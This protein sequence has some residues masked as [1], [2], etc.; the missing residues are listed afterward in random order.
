MDS[1]SLVTTTLSL[2]MII[3]ILLSAGF[4]FFERRDIGYTWAWLMLFYFIPILGFIIYLF[5]GRNLAKKNFFGLSSEERKYLQS[6]VDHQLATLNDQREDHN[7]LLTKYADLI[8]MNLVSSNALMTTDNEISIFNDGNQKFDALFDDIRHAKKEV[9][10]QYYIIQPDALGKK[11]RDELTIKA[12][13]GVK[14]RVLY[15]EIGSKRLSLKFFKELL[16]AGGE[17]EVFFPSLL[18]PINF[19]MNNRNHRKLCII[20]GEVAYIGGFNVGNEYLGID[21]KFGYWRDTHFRMKGD[22]VNQIQ[23]RFILD[24]KHAR[25]NERVILDQFSFNTE[26]HVGSSP[27]QIVSSG[28]NSLVEHLKNMYIKLILNA[29]RS[30]YIQ[31]PYFIPD[32]SFMDACKI[33]L[34]SGVDVRIMIPNKPDHPFVY[35]ATW[36]YAGELL[37]YGA[38]ILLY[39]NGFLH[40]KTIVVDDEVASVGTMNIDSRSFRL[41]FEVNAIVYDEQVAKQLQKLFDEDSQ[42]STELTP[43]RYKERSLIIKFKEGISRLFS[44]IL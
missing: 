10:I 42:L 24:W 37:K 12:K 29:K 22:S 27:V 19:R 34:L 4:L 16:S 18:R 25:K 33:A 13:E 36:A 44:S 23:G 35:W 6:A 40:A 11:L 41:N 39:E 21:K 26:A 43:E 9:N 20:D 7:P 8:H 2:V 15:D 30:V 17:V 14:V 31:T 32:S 28:P 1:N 5:L 38:K 3:N